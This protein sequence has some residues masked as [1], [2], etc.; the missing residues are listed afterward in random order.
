LL[1]TQAR[2]ACASEMEFLQKVLRLQWLA[3]YYYHENFND[4]RHNGQYDPNN[5]W[6][7]LGMMQRQ[8]LASQ[9]GTGATNIFMFPLHATVGNNKTE[10]KRVQQQVKASS[11]VISL[12]QD[13]VIVIPATSCNNPSSKKYSSCLASWVDSNCF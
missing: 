8:R 7:T 5:P 3:Q 1:E 9:K 13:G 4:V 11:E 12:D 10:A 2:Q 6:Y